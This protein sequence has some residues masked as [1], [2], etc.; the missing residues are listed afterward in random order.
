M[1]PLPSSRSIASVGALLGFAACAQVVGADFDR[2]R[3]RPSG[4]AGTGGGVT[5][6]AASTD[7]GKVDA[8]T[9]DPWA[10]LAHVKSPRRDQTSAL[11][12]YTLALDSK[13]LVVTA[14]YQ[15]IATDAGL[16]TRG[17]AAY[18]FDLTNASA[19]A[20][21]LVAPNVDSLDGV[22]PKDLTIKG[23]PENDW[24]S[25]R[26]ALNDRVIAIGVPVEASATAADPH[27]NSAPA[28]GAVYV[29][30]RAS[31]GS[32][33]QY[34]KAPGPQAGALFGESMSLS[35]SRLVVGAPEEDGA[36]TDS[37]AVYVYEWRDGHFDSSNPTRI[38][39]G[40]V[41]DGDSFGVSV[42]IEGDL[43]AVGATGDSS[44]GTGVDGDAS[45]TSAMGNGAVHIYRL[46]NGQ[47]MYQHYVKP[48]VSK[49]FGVFGFGLA[50][51]NG[52]IAIS[53]PDAL[54][55]DYADAV[56]A[57]SGVVYVAAPAGDSWAFEKCLSPNTSMPNLFGWSVA[58]AGDT[59]VVGAPWNYSG[60]FVD[61]GDGSQP[62]SGAAFMYGRTQDGDWLQTRFVKAPDIEANDVFGFS[63][64]LAPGLVAAGA[65]YE[66]GGPHDMNANF[67]SGAAYVFSAGVSADGGSP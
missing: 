29:Y 54:S 23:Y 65:P 15:D 8:R 39:P 57:N 11:F 19:P 63:V 35:D 3:L 43:L 16:K 59:L 20:V 56:P 4:D 7:A 53:A 33:P 62:F 51:S 12:G 14:P 36:A 45:D 47:W 52:R 10:L 27:D 64:A 60:S 21:P 41:H 34:L 1:A 18:V 58:L 37:G 61:P 32:L 44:A 28:A 9:A 50:I 66:A 24:G 67:Y 30:D 42:A 2:A 31:L 48:L 46:I 25:L 22:I 5:L 26:V 17:G 49:T 55:C 38:V 6:E 13:A 40:I